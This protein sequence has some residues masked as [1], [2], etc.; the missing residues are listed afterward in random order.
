M[1]KFL[2]TSI[3]SLCI[4]VDDQSRVV[5]SAKLSHCVDYVVLT[6]DLHT[7][8]VCRLSTGESWYVPV[9]GRAC[10]IAL[11]SGN[12]FAVLSD[13]GFV[14]RF[15]LTLP[16]ICLGKVSAPSSCSISYDHTGTMLVMALTNGMVKIYDLEIRPTPRLVAILKVSSGSIPL[17]GAR[18]DTL[19]GV[20]RGGRLF[21]LRSPESGPQILW[22]GAEHLDFDCYS[23]AIHPFLTR[24]V[25][26][27]FGSYVRYYSAFN[28]QPT[29]LLTSFN[30]IRDLVFLLDINQLAV[31][32][33]NGLEVWNLETNTVEFKWL[34]P[35][36]RVIAV[37][38]RGEDHLLVLWG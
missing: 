17:L 36:G 6:D 26:G 9:Q 16:T 5:K 35:S 4:S 23:M 28:V 22:N 20:D 31:V 14:Q 10:S 7:V 25:V 11:N 3:D 1:T 13:Q 8:R 15:D 33:D 32:G 27:G 29:N 30:Y 21:S 2:K 24:V 37:R 19:L 34:S 18:Q 38:P 12:E